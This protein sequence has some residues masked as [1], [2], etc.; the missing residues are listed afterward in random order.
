MIDVQFGELKSYTDWGLKLESITL[1]FPEAKTDQIDIPGA[2]GLLDLS[3]VNGQICYKNRTLTLSFSLEDDY[4]EWHDLS[5][6]IARVLHG[7]I[8]KCTLPDDLDHYSEGRF[9]LQ[10]DKKNDVIADFVIVGDV[11]PFKMEHLTAA[12]N[13]LW[14]PFS[15]ESGVARGYGEMQVSGFASVDVVGSDMPIVPEITCSAAMKVE[16]EGQTFELTKGMN[17][18]YDIILNQG[19]NTLKFTGTGT[20][21]ID[22]RGGV[23]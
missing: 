20:V 3:E 7:K 23:L 12:D 10:T 15:F 8:I 16:F 1:T 6:E 14:D 9:S 2:T 5:S 13:W 19:T 11:H 21:S 18:N 22:F 17:K 4:T